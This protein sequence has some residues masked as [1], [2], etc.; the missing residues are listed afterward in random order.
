MSRL[1]GSLLALSLVALPAAAET[2]AITNVRLE[3]VS[4]LGAVPKGTI[5]I[6]DGRIAAIGPQVA[7]PVGARM[8]DGQGQVVTPGFIAPSSNL[9]VSEVDQVRTTRDD[10]SNP[11]LTAGFDIQYGVNPNSPLIPL[12]RQTGL[13]LVVATPVLRGGENSHRDDGLSEATGGG[14]GGEGDPALFAGQA[15]A[16]SLRAGASEPVVR[17]KVALGLDLGEDGAR[18]AGGSRGAALVLVREALDDARTFAAHR[19]QYDRGE[20]RTFSMSRSDL[21]ALIPVIQGKTPLLVRVHRAADI[22]QALRLAAEQKVRMI[23]EGVEEGWMVANE[24]AKAGV[25]VIVDPQAD[26]PESFETL[27]S[28]LDNATRLRAAGVL[29]IITGSRDFTNLRQLRLNAGMA[30]ASG[31]AYGDALAAITLN[32]AK[33]YGLDS[34]RGSLEVGKSAD[35]VLW[36]GDPLETSSWPTVVF[37]DGVE[38]PSQTRAYELRDRYSKAVDGMPPAYR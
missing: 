15:A 9:T 34:Q 10:G 37:I 27:G 29:V 33:A 23:F 8:V 17:A 25:P 19:A 7:I 1:S 18:N 3:T 5:V 20:G 14:S 32:P 4:P 21:E 22:R 24:I 11:K 2:V 35:L 36:T 31:M 30:V 38:Q 16:V 12:A 13:T 28:R 26:L 6:T